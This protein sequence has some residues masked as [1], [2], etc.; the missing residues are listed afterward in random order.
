MF[1]VQAS[2]RPED[3][4]QARS[5]SPRSLRY[6]HLTLT[7]NLSPGTIG[8]PL[9]SSRKDRLLVPATVYS[10]VAPFVACPPCASA[11]QRQYS[12]SRRL[13]PADDNVTQRRVQNLGSDVPVVWNRGLQGL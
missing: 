6:L 11:M 4:V 1:S 9:N 3:P 13:V 5:P 10:S 12:I 8:S 2:V 7:W